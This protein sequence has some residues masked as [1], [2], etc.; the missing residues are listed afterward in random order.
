MNK[1]SHVNHNDHLCCHKLFIEMQ[2]AKEGRASVLI[3][4]D[5]RRDTIITSMM[6]RYQLSVQRVHPL[7]YMLYDTQLLQHTVTKRQQN[8]MGFKTTFA[9]TCKWSNIQ[10]HEMQAFV[11][12]MVSQML[13]ILC[14]LVAIHLLSNVMQGHVT[15]YPR[16]IVPCDPYCCVVM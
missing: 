11:I 14:F 8:I 15:Y 7:S 9:G 4:T 5:R 16:Y 12:H 2:V 6:T 10:C 1:T 13:P 3:L